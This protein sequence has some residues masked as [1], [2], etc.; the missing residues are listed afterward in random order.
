[1]NSNP[2]PAAA[3]LRPLLVSLCLLLSAAPRAGAQTPSQAAPAPAVLAGAST[4][5]LERV[6]LLRSSDGPEGARVT[7]ASDAPL[8]DYST[9]FDGDSFYLLIPHSRTSGARQV[10]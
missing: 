5:A 2:R 1:M 10:S 6:I 8:D 7:V 3:A 9:R 4:P